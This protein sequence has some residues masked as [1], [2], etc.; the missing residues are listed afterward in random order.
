M[1]VKEKKSDKIPT[2]NEGIELL[3]EEVDYETLRKYRIARLQEII[4]GLGQA[5][6]GGIGLKPTLSG[7]DE[8]ST[9]N[10]GHPG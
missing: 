5:N 9:E 2:H 3:D 1:E 4:T 7:E 10:E 8:P 6:K